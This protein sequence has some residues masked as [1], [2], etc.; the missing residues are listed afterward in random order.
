MN[1]IAKQK[2]GEELQ[3]AGED[4]CEQELLQQLEGCRI[5]PYK[6]IPPMEFLF[7]MFC[8]PCF[9]RGELVAVSGKAKRGKTFVSSILMS[10]CVKK[11][12]LSVERIEERPLSV[13]WFDTEQ[14]EESTQDILKNRI[15]RMVGDGNV[16]G[17]KNDNEDED[18]DDDE[19]DNEIADV[20]PEWERICHAFNVFNVRSKFW[21]ERLPML[22]VAVRHYRPDLVVLDGIRD[23]VN[24]INDG[25]LAQETIERLMHLSSEVRCCMVCILHQNKSAEDKN[26]RGWIGTELKNKAFEVYECEKDTDRVFTWSQTDTRKYDIVDKLRYKVDEDGIPRSC[27]VEEA[28]AAKIP[29]KM[30]GDG[31]PP[32]NPKYMTGVEGGKPRIDVEKLFKDAFSPGQILTAVQLQEKVMHMA[33]ITKYDF[34][35]WRRRDALSMGVIEAVSDA[36]GRACYRC[37][38][39]PAPP[40]PKAVQLE[41]FNPAAPREPP[42]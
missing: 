4:A 2:L 37:P 28:D 11:E 34:Y 5:T 12:V 13:L 31:R 27:S 23:L 17:N 8:R 9:P 40:A 41:M 25:V 30:E 14:S 16:D 29:Y 10:L 7:R 38:S 20:N 42:F 18:V 36:A 3:H 24:D 33:N 32:L 15:L 22:E 6:E 35:N 26:L 39:K 19:N 1:E 21:Q